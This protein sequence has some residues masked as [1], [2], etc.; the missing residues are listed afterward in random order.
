MG[1]MLINVKKVKH[2]RCAC[3]SAHC[4]ERRPT[5]D[6]FGFPPDNFSFTYFRVLLFQR[7]PNAVHL[8]QL[9][10]KLKHVSILGR[11]LFYPL[12][13]RVQYVKYFKKH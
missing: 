7:I 10:I 6:L 13:E 1:G 4:I 11:A 2:N 5:S 3:A 8:S 12:K 9:L